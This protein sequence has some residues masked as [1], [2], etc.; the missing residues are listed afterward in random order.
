[1]LLIPAHTTTTKITCESDQGICIPFYFEE[2]QI[3]SYFLKTG[4]KEMIIGNSG[5]GFTISVV[6]HWERW[7]KRSSVQFSVGQVRT[8]LNWL[9]SG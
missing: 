4:N 5:P 6:K 7:T 9:W 3:R 8:L 1:M 2:S